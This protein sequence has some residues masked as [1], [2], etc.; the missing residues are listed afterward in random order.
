MRTVVDQRIGRGGVGLQEVVLEVLVL[1]RLGGS[2]T[3]VYRLRVSVGGKRSLCRGS[4]AYLLQL[5]ECLKVYRKRVPTVERSDRAWRGDGEERIWRRRGLKDGRQMMV[6][7]V[8]RWQVASRVGIAPYVE[9]ELGDGQSAEQR[10]IGV[11]VVPVRALYDQRP[12]NER[13]LLLERM[14]LFGM[15]EGELRIAPSLVLW[16]GRSAGGKFGFL[17]RV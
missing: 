10:T 12:R 14:A 4:S 3:H 16:G 9:T 7:G 11:L 1:S 6:G 5:V 8:Q 15:D 2:W 13:L 17:S